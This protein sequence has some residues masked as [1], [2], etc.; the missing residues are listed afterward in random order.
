MELHGSNCHPGLIFSFI[1]L[2]SHSLGDT[3]SEKGR[4]RA[5]YYNL[6]MYS[7][8]KAYN[9]QSYALLCMR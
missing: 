9:L 4:L 8:V 6:H 2:L 1:F 7:Q 3:K 5:C